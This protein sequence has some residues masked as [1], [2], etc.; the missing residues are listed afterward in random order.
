MTN[1]FKQSYSEINNSNKFSV[2]GRHSSLFPLR[3]PGMENLFKLLLYEQGRLKE[4]VMW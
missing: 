3:L 1:S 4:L 2:S